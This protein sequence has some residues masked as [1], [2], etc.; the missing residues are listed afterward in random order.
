MWGLGEAEPPLRTF[1]GTRGGVRSIAFSPDGATIATAGS[2]GSMVI[3]DVADGVGRIRLEGHTWAALCVTFSPD[4]KTLAAGSEDSTVRLWN[5]GGWSE[6]A[7]LRGPIRAVTALRSEAMARLSPRRPTA[8]RPSGCGIQTVAA[9]LATL[10]LP[11]A[12]AGEGFSCLV[13]S[14]DGRTLYSGG[15]RGISA[16]DV[17]PGSKVLPP[18][19]GDTP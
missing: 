16:W 2:D 12:A 14:P 3:W 15:E 7:I 9:P 5:V 8:I 13:F 11:D 4:G 19:L 17:S 1:K 18:W 6:R 10:A